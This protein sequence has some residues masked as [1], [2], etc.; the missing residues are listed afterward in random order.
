M[1][2]LTSYIFIDDDLDNYLNY[3]SLNLYE[4]DINN[5]DYINKLDLLKFSKKYYEKMIKYQKN[6]PKTFSIIIDINNPKNNTINLNNCIIKIR[7]KVSIY[8]Y[9][10]T[11]YSFDRYEYINLYYPYYVALEMLERP[12]AIPEYI[13]RYN[14]NKIEN[15]GVIEIFYDINEKPKTTF[16]Q[17][18]EI[19]RANLIKYYK[20]QLTKL[21]QEEINSSNVLSPSAPEKEENDNP[22]PYKPKE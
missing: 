9:Y 10:F 19:N 18:E 20:K 5:F 7:K 14:V 2:N 8:K 11:K 4:D 21:E 17:S 15:N 16:K 12:Y 3:L 1:G 22:P 6:V 13:F